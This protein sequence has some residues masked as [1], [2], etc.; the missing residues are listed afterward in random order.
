[1]AKLDREVAAVRTD[2]TRLKWMVGMAMAGVAAQILK[3]FFG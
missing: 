2:I 3:M 1:M